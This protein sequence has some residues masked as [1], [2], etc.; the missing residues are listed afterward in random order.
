[1]ASVNLINKKANQIYFKPEVIHNFVVLGELFV[2]IY[3]L[4][5]FD[6]TC[7]FENSGIVGY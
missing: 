5:G 7:T 2:K 6:Q 4:L 3:S 1:M